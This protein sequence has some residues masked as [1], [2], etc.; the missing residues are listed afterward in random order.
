VVNISTIAPTEGLGGEVSAEGGVM[1][2]L[3]CEFINYQ[4]VMVDGRVVCAT[5]P[6]VTP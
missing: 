2:C 3:G 6:E 5:C 1:E 4:R